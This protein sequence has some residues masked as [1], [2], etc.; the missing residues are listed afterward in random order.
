MLFRSRVSKYYYRRQYG[1]NYIIKTEGLCGCGSGGMERVMYEYDTSNSKLRLKMKHD[2]LNRQTF[3]TYDSDDNV[4][5]TELKPSGGAI[6]GVEKW[7]YNSRGQV[8]TYK[9]RV[10][11]STIHE[12]VNSHKCCYLTS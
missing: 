6:I 8:L 12:K 2:A 11:Q 10:D 1:T 3:Y 5:Q 4:I 9:D 7:T